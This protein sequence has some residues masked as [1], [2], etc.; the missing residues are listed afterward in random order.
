MEE[1]NIDNAIALMRRSIPAD[2]SAKYDDDQLINL[3]DI[4]WDFY[5][6]NGLLEIDLDEEEDDSDAI[7]NELCDYATRMIR[8][9]KGAIIEQTHIMPLIQAEL[10]YEDSLLFE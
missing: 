9:D 2:A 6:Q 3:I 8:K 7:L 4:I 1:Y 10:N 5:E